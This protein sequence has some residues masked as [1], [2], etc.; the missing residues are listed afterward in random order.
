MK[1][2]KKIISLVIV[3][4]LINTNF[5]FADDKVVETTQAETTVQKELKLTWEDAFIFFDSL[6]TDTPFPYNY[7]QLRFPNIEK[8]SKIESALKKFV[9]LNRIPNKATNLNLKRE[10]NALDFYNLAKNVLE[11]G[12]LIE[13]NEEELAKRKVNEN[14]LIFTK[15]LYDSIWKTDPKEY[16]IINVSNSV[17]WNKEWIFNDVYDT[18][19]NWHYDYE[20]LNKDDLIY[21]AIEWLAKWTH[22]EHT[23][24]FPPLENQSFEDS[25]AWEFEWIWAY[26]EMAAPWKPRIVNPIPWSPAEKS[27]IKSWDIILKVNWKEVTKNNSLSEVTS[28]I[29]WPTGT[30]VTLTIDRDGEELDIDIIREKIIVK[31]LETEEI[32]SNIFSIKINSFW[33][34]VTNEFKNAIDELK[35][36]NNIKKVIIDLRNNWWW[37]LDEVT[38]MLSYL[39]AK[40]ENV[41]TVK[42]LWYTQNIYSNWYDWINLNNYKVVILQ[43]S[44]TASASEIMIWTLK[45]YFKNITII[46]ENTYWKGSVQTVREYTDGS[47]LKYTVAKWFTWWSET[48]ID[49]VWIAPDIELELDV[50]AYQNG[51]DNQL[52]KAIDY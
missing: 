50:E 3:I 46:W 22:D 23:V 44:G 51:T 15:N 17:L 24:Y 7:I 37:Y 29:K 5:V 9:Y 6:I 28:W 26:V 42:Y 48:W 18:L 14:D 40:W 1:K 12:W 45:D 27:W 10:I 49:W 36:K 34:W 52:Q 11:L 43:N 16:Q 35:W 39:V 4:L 19:L 13:L 25:L 21:S 2:L 38:E 20:N 47:S 31:N 32:N 33:V 30:K 41:A 8:N